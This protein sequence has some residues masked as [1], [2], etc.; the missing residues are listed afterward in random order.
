MEIA[1]NLRMSLLTPCH[2][3]SC[4]K[5][6]V[7]AIIVSYGTMRGQKTLQETARRQTPFC[8]VFTVLAA[9]RSKSCPQKLTVPVCKPQKV[10][11][12]L[13]YI[14]GHLL[15]SSVSFLKIE[16]SPCSLKIVILGPEV[17]FNFLEKSGLEIAKTRLVS[18]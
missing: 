14:Y 11:K 10:L 1:E 18:S 5:V 4:A 17:Y 2:A 6:S 3:C 15:R 12:M 13:V 8:V 7:S 16:D 9:N